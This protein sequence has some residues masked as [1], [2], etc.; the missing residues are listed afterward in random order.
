MTSVRPAK[1]E[2]QPPMR[3]NAFGIRPRQITV[4]GIYKI[5]EEPQSVYFEEQ[6]TQWIHDLCFKGRD[7]KGSCTT[8]SNGISKK[9]TAYLFVVV[10]V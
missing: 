4:F 8:D 5:D 9:V 6:T 1:T 10:V 2:L 3:P 7:S